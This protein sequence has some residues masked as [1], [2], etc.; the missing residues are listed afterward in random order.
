MPPL[1]KLSNKSTTVINNVGAID[2]DPIDSKS[3]AVR[4]KFLKNKDNIH[5]I[6]NKAAKN[7]PDDNHKPSKSQV[8]Y[9]VAAS[10]QS[11]PSVSSAISKH[12]RKS[13]LPLKVKMPFKI[14]KKNA[15]SATQIRKQGIRQSDDDVDL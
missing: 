3:N 10:K 13:S 8:E 14:T 2:D 12:K 11:K 5:D 7:T 4:P 6:S 9:P 1:K 15:E